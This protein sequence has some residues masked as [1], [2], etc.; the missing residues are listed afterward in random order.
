MRLHEGVRTVTGVLGAKRCSGLGALLRAALFA[1]A[2][3]WSVQ[4]ASGQ[5]QEPRG[6]GSKAPPKIVV[7]EIKCDFSEVWAGTKI[8]HAWTIRNEG[9]SILRII[10]VK[11]SCGCTVLKN[12]DREILPGEAG[13]LPVVIDTTHLRSKVHKIVKVQSNDPENA[14]ITLDIAGTVNQRIGI[15][16]TRG[17][18]F[19]RIKPNE[20]VKRTL[21]LTNNTDGPVELSLLSSRAGVFEMELTETKPGQSWELK[22]RTTP[23]Y[24]EQYNRAQVR[25]K[26]NIT[27]QPAVE[28]P[29]SVYVLPKVEVMPSTVIIPTA[30][31]Q[32]RKQPVRVTFNTD[33]SY[34]VLSATADNDQI[35]V[36]VYE[37][38]PNAYTITLDMPANYL[39]PETGG[40][41]TVKTNHPDYETLRVDITQRRT[42][43]PRPEPGQRL[44]GKPVPPAT[45][46]T[47]EGEIL[48]TRETGTVTVYMFYASW[49]GYCKRALPQLSDMYEEF[50]E[51]GV[52]FVGV[53]QDSIVEYGANPNNQ[54]SRTKE[55]VIQQWKDMGIS[56]TQA[57][58]PTQSGRSQ[59]TVTGLPTMLLV[60][61]TGQ[62]ERVYTGGAALASGSLKKEVADLVAG[63]KLPLQ[64]FA[65]RPPQSSK[66][67][68][69][70]LQGKPAP[71]VTFVTATEESYNAVEPEQVSF[72]MFYASWCGHCKKALPKIE[73]I[74]KK[75]K[76]KPV[77]F[78][79]VSLDQIVEFGADPNDRRS[80]SMEFVVDQFKDYGLTFTQAFDPDKAGQSKYKV[81]SF[82][83]MFLIDQKGNVDKVY[84]GRQ[85]VEDGSL[86]RDIEALLAKPDK[87]QAN[88]SETESATVAASASK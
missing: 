63:K 24:Q 74:T 33:E 25:L 30:E 6:E 17:G 16:P 11:P 34:K 57:F 72:T 70:K 78:A 28:F 20:I 88:A 4:N 53:N 14:E 21:T 83:T 40:K 81:T 1:A 66:R 51:K 48:N 35:K 75:Y 76:D 43:R 15:E 41:L 36:N 44:V 56:F 87:D 31:P 49:C 32:P 69:Q 42:Q 29:A 47:A 64:Q 13:K 19:G 22:L 9:Q 5:E 38:R 85:A 86:Q 68:A 39:P 45:F 71:Q 7:D 54:R 84:I 79:A 46:D 18:S 67:P 61:K 58:D 77:R 26:T 65:Q 8:E 12:Y 55:Q 27:D 52:R 2:L 82:P 59:F 37:T 10:S 73:E 3:G 80:K 50:R 62:V 23:P 60:G